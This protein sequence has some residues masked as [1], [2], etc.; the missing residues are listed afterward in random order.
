M[1]W[2]TDRKMSGMAERF[3]RQASRPYAVGNGRI[4]AHI[5]VR[6]S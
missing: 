5:A 1:C 2:L 4:R 6:D 3:S